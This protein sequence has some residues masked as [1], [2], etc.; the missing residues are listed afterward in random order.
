MVWKCKRCGLKVRGTLPPVS[1]GILK[2]NPI[3]GWKEGRCG[4]EFVKS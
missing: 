4:G 2:G 3:G 1:H